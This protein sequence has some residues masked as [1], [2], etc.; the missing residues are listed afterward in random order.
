MHVPTHVTVL[1][2]VA[3]LLGEGSCI[4]SKVLPCTTIQTSWSYNLTL[5]HASIE[6]GH[7][8]AVLCINNKEMNC[9]LN[10]C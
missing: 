2:C 4:V 3:A 5:V 10:K 6:I 1:V 9:I 7:K 8:W